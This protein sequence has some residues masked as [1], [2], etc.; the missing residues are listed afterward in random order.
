MRN[1][2]FNSS[3][4]MMDRKRGFPRKKVCRFC[5]NKDLTLDYKNTRL[6]QN[7]IT[8]R[9]KILPRRITG[10][11][12]YHQRKLTS[13]VKRARNIALLPSGPTEA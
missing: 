3:E 2:E 10:N 1:R 8:D 7:F 4:S 5:E 13:A 11:C 6:L 9:G 12:A